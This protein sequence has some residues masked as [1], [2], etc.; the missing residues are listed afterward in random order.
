MKSRAP[1]F[2]PGRH[3]T[4]GTKLWCHPMG[5]QTQGLTPALRKSPACAR[6]RP[7]GRTSQSRHCSSLEPHA[8]TMC[9]TS[10]HDSKSLILEAFGKLS[11]K[12]SR[13]QHFQKDCWDLYRHLSK[14]VGYFTSIRSPAKNHPKTTWGSSFSNISTL[15]Y[16]AN[17]R[18]KRA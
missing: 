2:F 18:A 8:S 15:S 14:V 9:D 5:T 3:A 7:E 11:L 6:H 12:H 13:R 4:P 17:G 16:C 10:V 1:H